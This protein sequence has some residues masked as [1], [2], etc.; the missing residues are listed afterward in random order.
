MSDVEA[1][2]DHSSSEIPAFSPEASPGIDDE[3]SEDDTDDEEEECEGDPSSELA[4][5]LGAIK[6]TIDNLY[7]VS[8]SIRNHR[9]KQS[10]YWKAESYGAG[11]KGTTP[12]IVEQTAVFDR[13]HVK[14]LLREMRLD[15]HRTERPSTDQHEDELLINRLT[16]GISKRRRQLLYWERH[17][18][19]L[20][21]QPIDCGIPDA[22]RPGTQQETQMPDSRNVSLD[23]PRR[24]GRPIT[25]FSKTVATDYERLQS[26]AACDTGSLGK[27]SFAS[28]TADL[29]GNEAQ[30][31]GPP[32]SDK[33]QNGFVC[34]YCHVLCPEKDRKIQRRWR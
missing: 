10:G 15:E 2:E 34:P 32:K 26:E 27:A 25:I 5:R 16:Q 7:E 11:P 24:D 29:E 18:Q 22:S 3:S 23:A 33:D 13:E 4:A 6:R 19:K 30:F 14:E 8:F 17:S 9:S 20:A 12:D 21:F 31:P 1:I 28:T